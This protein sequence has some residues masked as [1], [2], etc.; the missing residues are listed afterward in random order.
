MRYNL[1]ECGHPIS[2]TRNKSY[3]GIREGCNTLLYPIQ[4]LQCL[5]SCM[6]IWIKHANKFNNLICLKFLYKR[7]FFIKLCALGHHE[8]SLL[9]SSMSIIFVWWIDLA[10]LHLSVLSH[11]L[12][13]LWVDLCAVWIC[14]F[15]QAH[16]IT[17]LRYIYT[18]LIL[19]EKQFF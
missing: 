9:K 8:K 17:H 13:L 16:I 10:I 15:S 6:S 19:N 11:S 5:F 18:K 7:T 12:K 4:S 1:R 14:F 3:V 2:W